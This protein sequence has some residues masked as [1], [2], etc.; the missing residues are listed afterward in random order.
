[1]NV[2]EKKGIV[3]I[4]QDLKVN[5][6]CPRCSSINFE[7]VGETTIKVQGEMTFEFKLPMIIVACSECAF[8]T[9][10]AKLML[11]K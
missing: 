4:L 10:H 11:Q 6:P 9:F 7:V 8:L 2:L 1:M 5:K 3:K